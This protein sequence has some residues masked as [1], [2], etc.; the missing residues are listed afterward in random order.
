MMIEIEGKVINT[1]I[2]RRRFVCDISKCKGT[3][4][5]DGDSGAPL[6]KEELDKLTEVFPAVEP[7]LSDKEREEISRQGL[8]VTDADGDFVTPI[9]DGRECV[10]T[11]REPDGTWSCAIEKAFREGKTNWRKPIS[12]YLYPIRVSKTRKYELLNFHEWEVCRPAMELGQKVGTPAYK[13]LR[14]PIIEKFGEDFY[15][16]LEELEQELSRQGI[17]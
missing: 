6:E 10:Y 15:K 8:W 14:E 9:I 1:E 16:E 7:L 5:Y 17:I 11:N 13:F 12:C 4:C 2:F 3:C